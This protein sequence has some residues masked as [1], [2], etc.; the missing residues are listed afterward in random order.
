MASGFVTPDG[1]AGI[2]PSVKDY[3]KGKGGKKDGKK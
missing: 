2:K 1:K 3:G